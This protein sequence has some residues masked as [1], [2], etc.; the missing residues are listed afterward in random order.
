MTYHDEHLTNLTLEDRL[1]I[2]LLVD[3]ELD[4]YLRQD[5]L[6]RLNN[7]SG[8]WRCCALSFLETQCFRETF[9][10]ESSFF[11]LEKIESVL[12]N[13]FA[14]R[15]HDSL[16]IQ[17]KAGKETSRNSRKSR[18][19]WRP[20][21]AATAGG[22]LAALVISAL[23]T[24]TIT[25]TNP[26]SRIT[27]STHSNAIVSANNPLSP[28]AVPSNLHGASDSTN[29]S[30]VPLRVVTLK[31]TSDDLD[32]IS[33]PCVETD[34]YPVSLSTLRKTEDNPYA[35]YLRRKGHQVETVY[36]DLMFPL[37]DGRMVILPV[38]TINVQYKTQK[39]YQ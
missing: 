33:V 37:G 39:Q 25:D 32:G 31:S 18:R 12:E 1:Q 16:L 10:T 26:F 30:P 2:E 22:F 4:E 28:P 24:S 20:L 29:T 3:G 8:G 21:F 35:E 34:H 11:K 15:P 19:D 6:V 9:K 13:P 23:L 7:I 17:M 14:N 5:L 27:P 38:D 36:E